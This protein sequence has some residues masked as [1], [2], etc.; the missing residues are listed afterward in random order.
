MVGRLGLVGCLPHHRHTYSWCGNCEIHSHP[1]NLGSLI[2]QM[3]VGK[4]DS[5]IPLCP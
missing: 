2:H 3:R 5:K 1:L 4:G